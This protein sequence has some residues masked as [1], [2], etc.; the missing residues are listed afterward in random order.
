MPVLSFLS[1]V[2]QHDLKVTVPMLWHVYPVCQV[3]LP[4]H[5]VPE[6][7]VQRGAVPEG[8]LSLDAVK[9]WHKANRRVLMRSP[10]VLEAVE[11]Y[12]TEDLDCL[13]I[14]IQKSSS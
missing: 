8:P 10:G 5:N 4:A 1:R 6:Q 11:T 12:Y 9:A 14:P 13:G 7:W 2:S 3:Q